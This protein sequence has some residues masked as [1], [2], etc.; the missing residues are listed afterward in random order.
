MKEQMHMAAQYLAAAGISFLEKK[1]DDSHTNLGFD[2][3]SGCLGT[4]ILSKNN[5]QLLLNYESFSLIWKSNTTKVSFTLHD[6]THQEVIEWIKETSQSLLK[7]EYSY[8]L[9]YDLPYTINDSYT[10]ALTNSSELKALMH[11]RILTQFSLEE[12][13]QLY[14]LD[15]SIRVWPHHFDTGIYSNWPDSNI[16]IGLGLAIPDSVSDEHYLYASGYNSDG[17]LATKGFEK[18]TKG[19]WCNEGYIGAVLSANKL[20]KD[21][22][23]TFFKE[24][25]HQFKNY[26]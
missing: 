21:E 11:L 1:D 12:V 18:L 20:E 8:K 3:E 5:D 25:V 14:S 9:H 22:A 17:Q 2:T 15:T 13:T 7:K 16:S 26:K 23:I 4:H 19:Y 24:A 10:F 6:R